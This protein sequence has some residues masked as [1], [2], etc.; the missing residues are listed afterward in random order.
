MMARRQREL[1]FGAPAPAAE[2]TVRAYVA[3]VRRHR[4]CV[5]CG[6]DE[7]L[8]FLHREVD[9]ANV[10]IA[11]LVKAGV[12]IGR[13]EQEL[14]RCVVVC[15]RHQLRWVA[16]QILRSPAPAPVGVVGSRRTTRSSAA[17]GRRAA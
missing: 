10:P 3:W 7:D 16:P 15:R 4:V 17:K 8:V 9:D 14:R 1:P 13:I 2:E 5:A 6:G 12:A 11:H